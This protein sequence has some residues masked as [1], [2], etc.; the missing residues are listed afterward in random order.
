[1]LVPWSL[2]EEIEIFTNRCH[3]LKV[4]ISRIRK[5]GVTSLKTIF[6]LRYFVSFESVVNG[7]RMEIDEFCLRW[8]NHHSVLISVL[9]SLLQ[10]E[11]LVDVTLAA[12][13]Q[14]IEVHRLVL[15]ACSK[16]FEVSLFFLFLRL[17]GCLM[18]YLIF[19]FLLGFT[20]YSQKKT[21]HHI[22]Q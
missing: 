18:H 19:S 1:M 4:L 15:C 12:D 2:R 6:S 7:H 13:G 3:C 21:I 10:K 16:Y 8:N 22:P 11:L 14:Y 17:T 9:N 20:K 5:I